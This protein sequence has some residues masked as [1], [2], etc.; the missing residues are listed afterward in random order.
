M[1]IQCKNCNAAL[2]YDIDLFKQE[3][4]KKFR[5]PKC[6]QIFSF[7]DLKNQTKQN[8][9]YISIKCEKCQANL[10]IAKEKIKKDGTKCRC[11][12]C[13]NIFKV[14]PQENYKILNKEDSLLNNTLNRVDLNIERVK[15]IFTK[16]VEN[17]GYG[18]V[19]SVDGRIAIIWPEFFKKLE[20]P[21][22]EHDEIEFDIIPV[23]KGWEARNLKLLQNNE[24]E[25]L[26]KIKGTVIDIFYNRGYGFIRTE[27]DRDAFIWIGNIKE[28]DKYLKTGDKVKFN[29]F[30]GQK[31]WA[32]K[33]VC[34]IKEVNIYDS[35]S[36]T[37]NNS[38]EK[39]NEENEPIEKIK[40]MVTAVNEIKGY[41]FIKAEDN[42]NVFVWFGDITYS[43]H[44]LKPGDQVEFDIIETQ[45]GW[46][47]KNVKYIE[48]TFESEKNNG[49][50]HSL[51]LDDQVK[52]DIIEPQKDKGEKNDKYTG[53]P[54]ESKQM[55]G[56]VTRFL[57]DRSYGFIKTDDGRDVFIHNDELP[58][59]Q[60]NPKV[61]NSIQFE[62]FER[63]QG[64]A[65]R[66]AS[67]LNSSY[68]EEIKRKANEIYN[69]E[70]K[71]KQNLFVEEIK[72]QAKEAIQKGNY[73]NAVE[74]YEK[75]ISTYPR[76][77]TFISYASIVREYDLGNEFE[78][79]HKGINTFPSSGPL[80]E[81]YSSVLRK[82][83]KLEEAKKMVLK[84]IKSTSGFEK[85]LY[86]QL[87][88]IYAEFEDNESLKEGV[89]YFEKAKQF[90]SQ[91]TIPNKLIQISL[92]EIGQ[93]I[94]KSL[95]KTKLEPKIKSINKRYA[96]ITIKTDYVDFFKYYNI[97]G[98][99]LIRYFFDDLNV[100]DIDQLA[101]NIREQIYNKLNNNLAFII[102]KDVSEWENVYWNNYKFR[103]ETIIPVDQDDIALNSCEHVIENSIIKWR[104]KYDFFNV[105]VPVYGND[106][107]GREKVLLSINDNIKQGKP[108]G[109]YGLRRV[110][111][112]SIMHKLKEKLPYDIVIYYNLQSATHKDVKFLY[113]KIS[114]ELQNTISKNNKLSK[115]IKEL[116]LILGS[117][118]NYDLLDKENISTNFNKDLQLILNKLSD[119]HNIVI[120]I[121]E[122]EVMLPIKNNKGF[123]GSS[124]FLGH[125]ES[126][127][128]NTNGRV[129]SI[130][131]AANSIISEQGT[132]DNKD[133]P[134][135]ERY[136]TIYIPTFEKSEHDE[137]ITQ[138]G[139]KMNVSF[140][141][142]SLDFIFNETGGHPYI[143]RQFCSS[144]IDKNK[145]R[146]LDVN[147]DLAEEISDYFIKDKGNILEEIMNRIKN[148]P[149]EEEI[150]RLILNGV[151]AESELKKRT[152]K[153]I[154][155]A[156]RHLKGYNLVKEDGFDNY[157]IT[158][159]LLC[160]WFKKY[161]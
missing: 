1:K 133:N 148:F 47:A 137:M 17:M 129:I 62:I 99:I 83:G 40:G 100:K 157:I 44:L 147:L 126:I 109:I 94:F 11:M 159:N 48:K 30:H 151:A 73:L 65:A 50:E 71:R 87:A 41:G 111:K 80:Y 39:S 88:L 78:I 115:D 7:D 10:K 117:E 4:S 96:D 95:N 143:I 16:F 51:K 76:D 70:I 34:A 6:K 122:L 49:S 112:T 156:L 125:L 114:Q 31:G 90:G 33:N 105:K 136:E 130:L 21:L 150:I 81:Y 69:E 25:K 106:F 22:K 24:A 29:I 127:C 58:D 75:S 85:Q 98:I 68:N 13:N 79:L 67:I 131:A 82:S 60:K 154:G 116:K 152:D 26:E 55:R 107:F 149:L 146:P 35:E 28:S 97:D 23:N 2:K 86:L 64:W 43:E 8:F 135:F 140:T 66:N 20:Q 52:F 74:L 42:R 141:K 84:G 113:W 124:G 19:R 14:Y 123:D 27:D 89:K 134:L 161:Q 153:N 138:L 108:T 155:Q 5:C 46:G 144:I 59:S 120:Q 72:K 54:L 32:G 92:P 102:Q 12:K 142:E 45:K 63:E 118:Q 132:I 15:G 139:D 104:G 53:K 158:I 9:D 3:A 18:F 101:N 91:S 145:S 61:G 119:K 36:N 93:N 128:R 56:I 77:H 38:N 160:K 37:D 121:D 103:Y 110:G 57:N